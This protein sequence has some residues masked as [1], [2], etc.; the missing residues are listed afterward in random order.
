M[1]EGDAK[2]LTDMESAEPQR[3]DQDELGAQPDTLPNAPEAAAPEAAA[4]E[5][6]GADE[7]YDA[8]AEASKQSFP[9]SDAPGWIHHRG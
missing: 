5:T 3:R 7:E 8:V 1:S 2:T 6:N 4:P 9:A